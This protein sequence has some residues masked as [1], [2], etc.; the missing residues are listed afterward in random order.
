MFGSVFTLRPR[1]GQEDDLQ[2]LFAEWARERRPAVK[3]AV[4]S[5]LFRSRAR[6]G[7]YTGV[8]IFDSEESYVANANAPAQD[9]WYRRLREC[10]TADPEWND[11]EVVASFG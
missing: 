6:P 7:E 8:A 3:G 2:G 9:L 4:A 5:Y 10:L 11:G 1:P